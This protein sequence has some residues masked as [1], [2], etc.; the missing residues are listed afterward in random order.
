MA[1][2]LQD[3][4]SAVR[5][6]TR[7]YR[8]ECEINFPTI[9]G[10]SSLAN[11]LCHS[12]NFPGRKVDATTETW[13]MGQHYKLAGDLSYTPWQGTFRIDDNWDVYK[14]MKAWHEVV[15]G[16]ET[17][18]SAFPTGYKSSVTLYQ[19]DVAG[20]RIVSIELNGA[21]PTAVTVSGLDTTKRD[22]L[23]MTVTWQYDFN[24]FTV[25]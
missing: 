10:S 18:I 11:I 24:K 9:V 4:R 14:K 12:H 8:F 17:N 21:W 13:F 6:L 15:H 7:G 22:P 16:T 25:L 5:D 2:K 20:N 1:F 3:F 19:L 23:D